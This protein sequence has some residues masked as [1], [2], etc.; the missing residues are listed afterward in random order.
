M[1]AT[2]SCTKNLTANVGENIGLAL[3]AEMISSYRQ[4]NANDVVSYFVGKNVIM[5]I[6]AQSDCVGI[7]FYNAYNEA[8]EKTL[9][10]VGVD[11][12]GKDMLQLSFVNN[13]GALDQSPAIVA[14]RIIVMHDD[15]IGENWFDF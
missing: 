8:G 4:Q 13:V 10:Y 2:K 15:E 14:D 6:L 5:E 3:G 1:V 11:S 12:Q 9:V 7:N